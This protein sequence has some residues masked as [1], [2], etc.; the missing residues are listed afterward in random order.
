MDMEGNHGRRQY[1]KKYEMFICILR[2]LKSLF[3]G[4]KEMPKDL[5]YLN[6]F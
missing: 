2:A 5:I 3:S 1:S 4:E 6:N